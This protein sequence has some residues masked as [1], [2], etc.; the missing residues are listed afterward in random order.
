MVGW[1]V[2][3]SFEYK[4][5]RVFFGWG[6]FFKKKGLGLDFSGLFN[7]KPLEKLR[8]GW[9]FQAARWSGFDPCSSAWRSAWKCPNR[10][11]PMSHG[12]MFLLFED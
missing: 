6:D 7:P 2:L 5:A 11:R 3:L 4:Y 8:K 9:L 1:F 10:S 12:E